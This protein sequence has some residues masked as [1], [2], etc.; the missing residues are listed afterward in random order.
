MTD[1]PNQT[2]WYTR[3][4]VPSP[5]GLAARLGW[6]DDAFAADGFTVS[7]ILDSRDGAVRESHF[8]HHL[9]WSFRQGGNIPAIWARSNGRSTRLVGLTWTDEFQ[10]IITLPASG[11]RRAQDLIGRR[12]GIPRRTNDSIDFHR[13]TALKGMVSGL[14]AADIAPDA[15]EIVPIDIAEKVLA[16]PGDPALAGLRRR[17]PYWHELSALLRGEV[18]AIFVKGAEGI[19]VTNLAAAVVVTEF[20]RHP[21]PAIRINNGTPRTLTIDG[22]LAEERPDL[23][24]RLVRL[25]ARAGAWAAEHPEETLSFVAREILTSEEAVLASNGADVHQQLGIGLDPAHIAAIDHFKRF[26]IDWNILQHDFDADA[27]VDRR[28]LEAAG[29]AAAA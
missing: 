18:D 12:F 10:A 14:A 19:T 15:V 8:D 13:A 9:A 28:P 5:L 7:A 24:A 29:L 20:G 16:R 22:W 26:L 3:C 21:D 1:H 27:W 4:P 11:I 17:H 2:L 6:V 23:A 25:V